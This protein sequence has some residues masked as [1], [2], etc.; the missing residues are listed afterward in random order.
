M[1]I[2]PVPLR[3]L[4]WCV[5]LAL[6][7]CATSAAADYVK[8]VLILHSNQSI[9]PATNIVDT[10]IRHEL[11]PQPPARIE[12]YSEFLDAERFP[13]P[14]QETPDPPGR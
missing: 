6:W 10:S 1:R 5:A 7:C 13:E 2:P 8:R 3:L 12:A 11:K 14:E 4:S 9:L